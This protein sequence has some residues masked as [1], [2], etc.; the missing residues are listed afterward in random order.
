METRFPDATQEDLTRNDGV[1]IICREDMSLDTKNKKLSVVMFTTWDV[2]GNISTIYINH[3]DIF[4]EY[5][6]Q[7]LSKSQSSLDLRYLQKK[8]ISYES[9]ALFDILQA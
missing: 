8:S 9:S 4:E 7:D 6:Q 2:W 5:L 1:C 3:T